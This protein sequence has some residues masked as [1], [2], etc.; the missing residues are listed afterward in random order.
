MVINNQLSFTVN[1]RLIFTPLF[2]DY[3]LIGRSIGFTVRVFEITFGLIV[4]AVVAL[5]YPL[6]PLVWILTPV[7][8][9]YKE[10]IVTI[11]IFVGI[12]IF[13]SLINQNT[14]EKKINDCTDDYLYSFRP[15][16][17][18][19]LYLITESQVDGVKKLLEIASIK[20]LLRRLE[21]AN[22]DFSAKLCFTLLDNKDSVATN[23]YDFAKRA[24]AT[25]VD[26]ISLFMG[27]LKSVTNLENFLANFNTKLRTVEEGTKWIIS[28]Q[29]RK[30]HVYPWQDEYYG[31]VLGGFGKGMTGRV[32]PFL[33]SMSEDFTRQALKIGY[34]RFSV[35]ESTINKL[36]ALLGASTENV[37]I[38][39]EPGS[40][41]T[42]VVKG[43]AY[44]I[45]RGT[46]NISLSNKRIVSLELSGI[47]TGTTSIGEIAEKIKYAMNEAKGSGNIILF[48][49]EIHN[50]VAG[51][52]G[53]SPE[54]SAIFNLLEPELSTGNIQ[55][56]GATN[57][58]N[59]RKYIEP[60]GAFSRLFHLFEIQEADFDETFRILEY[61]VRDLEK[62]KNIFITYGALEK[63]I[64]LSK[65][66]MHER[67]LPDKAVQI[68]DRAATYGEGGNRI[69]DSKLIAE[70]MADITHVPS[71]VINDDEAKKIL[72]IDVEM[73]KMV[74][75]QDHAI[76]QISSALKRARAGIRN[77]DKPI[78]S[79]LF[80]GTTGVGK[81][82][83][84][85][86]LAKTYFG[87]VKT[88]I[89]IDMSE[90]QQQDSLSRLLG[91]PD[92][93]T[94][95]ILTEAVRSRPFALVLLDELEKAHSGVLLTF[96][97]VLDD[98]RLTD[99]SGTTI[100]FTNTII[101]ATSNVG[102]RSIQQTFESNGTLEQMQEAAMKDVR[103]T[104]AP[105]FLNRFSGIIVFNPLTMENVRDITKIMLDAITQGAS[106]KNIKLTFN[107][108]LV[109][110]L[111]KRGYSKEWGAR[112]LARVIE[113]TVET[114]IAEKILSQELKPGSEIELGMEVLNT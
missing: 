60:N 75:G 26:E 96:L 56:I 51:G 46:S 109:E 48:I 55:F 87:S 76:K 15:K 45:M 19:I 63:S 1:L 80:V 42:S 83:T 21:L 16:T 27:F 69:V 79:F 8:F 108:G 70:V 11:F 52:G 74:V 43:M 31:M 81:T 40:G 113:D 53:S 104:F 44:Q 67:V 38:V 100:D 57:K 20:N 91:S 17:L 9:L 25:Y 77:E 86:A 98:G 32:T 88:M 65:K 103:T 78:A 10:G 13:W 61:V 12:Y 49:D 59:Y 93:S 22:T 41:K 2:G 58:Q 111:I 114:Y 64:E 34:E 5:L 66:L 102:T 7:Y 106:E 54:I 6:F 29:D 85:K 23:A 47:L 18:S 4:M 33:D 105:E 14:P 50:L 101:I 92:G 24:G 99:S 82:Q 73:K 95:G 110:E 94:K 35:R 90:Y 30:N 68:I 28:E 89:R 72:A 37:L 3:T 107:N 62:K 39:G 97:Q 71:A 36:S 84:A 112:P